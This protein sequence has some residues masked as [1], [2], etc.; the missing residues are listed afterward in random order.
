MINIG[1]LTLLAAKIGGGILAFL[2]F[3]LIRRMILGRR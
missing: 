3:Y 2:I 1:E